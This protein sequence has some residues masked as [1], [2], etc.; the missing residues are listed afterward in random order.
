MLG[1]L[2]S[3]F[4]F[5]Q[6]RPKSVILAYRQ[7]GFAPALESTFGLLYSCLLYTSQ[8]PYS[9]I[10]FNTYE[11]AVVEAAKPSG[12]TPMNLQRYFDPTGPDGTVS[13][14]TAPGLTND[15]GAV[16]NADEFTKNV[17]ALL[18]SRKGSAGEIWKV[19]NLKKEG[20]KLTGTCLLYTSRC[21]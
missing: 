18:V 19:S 14:P 16:F 4:L 1:G 2:V 11:V 9:N 15:A 6:S 8:R 21:V 12:D 13:T 7:G 17:N 5:P 20:S 10:A 3:V